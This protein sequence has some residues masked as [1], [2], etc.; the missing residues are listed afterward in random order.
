MASEVAIPIFE[1]KPEFSDNYH[2][3]LESKKKISDHAYDLKMIIREF[4]DRIRCSQKSKLCFRW[5]IICIAIS[6][7]EE[8]FL[9]E[10]TVSILFLVL[11]N[12]YL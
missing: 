7:S 9:I 5:L 2:L 1:D 4:D 8:H 10:L 6:D 3:N 12:I 11:E